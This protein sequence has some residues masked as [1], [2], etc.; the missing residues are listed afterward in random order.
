MFRSLY[1]LDFCA[2]A[3][4]SF[5]AVSSMSGAQVASFLWCTFSRAITPDALPMK[6]IGPVMVSETFLE[7]HGYRKV[8]EGSNAKFQEMD[9]SAS[10]MKSFPALFIVR[11]WD[12]ATVVAPDELMI[13]SDVFE[14]D[15]MWDT[16]VTNKRE[17]ATELRDY[18][19]S[20]A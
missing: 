19:V 16:A 15:C 2:T 5:D 10:A 20:S 4:L 11:V 13:S 7:G 9:P 18:L 6:A 8:G 14:E 3:P 17:I 1:I 12:K